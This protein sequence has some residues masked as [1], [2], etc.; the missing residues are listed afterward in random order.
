MI[1]NLKN[2]EI[3]AKKAVDEYENLK[4]QAEKLSLHPI[5]RLN[6]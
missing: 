3:K 2:A 6:K 1:K 4:K 5:K